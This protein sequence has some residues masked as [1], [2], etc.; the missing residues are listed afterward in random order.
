MATLATLTEDVYGML[1][2]S[3]QVERPNEDTLATAVADASD[4][5]WQFDTETLWKRGDYAED[6]AAGEIVVMAEHHP[7][8]ADVTVRRA[9][10]GTTAASS[11]AQGD[12]FY[13]NPV[14]PRYQIERYINE[15]IDNDLYPHV[16]NVGETSFMWVTG[17]TRYEMPT[18]CLDVIDV[19][20]VDVSGNDFNPF[21]REAWEF[22]QTVNTAE[23][24]NGNYLRMPRV[25]DPD[26]AVYVTYKQ[27]PLSSAVSTLSTQLANMVPWKVVGKLLG[28]TRVAPSRTDPGRSTPIAGQGGDRLIRDFGF[29]DVEFRRMR[30]DESRRLRTQVR[31]QKVRRGSKV[32]RG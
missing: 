30:Q 26:A 1:Y 12:V 9:Q 21:P 19:Y 8:S 24:T 15:T 28:G 2:G 18:D 17:T 25:Y 5:E 14:F 6:A 10:R 3:A 13:K 29:F 22:R 27:Q 31:Q 4:V 20:Q 23:S 7:T 16:W 11:Y 32:R